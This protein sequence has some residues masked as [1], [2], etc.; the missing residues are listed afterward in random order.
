M[1]FDTLIENNDL[2]MKYEI[3]PKNIKFDFRI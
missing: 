2:Q 1:K 3:W